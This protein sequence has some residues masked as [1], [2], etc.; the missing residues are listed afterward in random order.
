MLDKCMCRGIIKTDA[1]L[2][3]TIH[4]QRLR[5]RIRRWILIVVVAFFSQAIPDIDELPMLWKMISAP[6][7]SFE[8]AEVSDE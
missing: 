7:D 1:T 4:M 8:L 5:R 6:A 3:E 2:L